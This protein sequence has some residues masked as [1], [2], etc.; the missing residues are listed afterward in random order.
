MKKLLRGCVSTSQRGFN[1]L[2]IQTAGAAFRYSESQLGLRQYSTSHELGR[3]VNEVETFD[4]TC[5]S[6][7]SITVDLYNKSL[8]TQPTH[9]LFL[10]LPSTG[11]HLRSNHPPIPSFLASDTT[12]LACI[13]YRWNRISV[14]SQCVSTDLSSASYPSPPP[15]P[16]LLSS[17]PSFANHAFPTPLHDT[18]HA[19]NYLT[20]SLLPS[21]CPLEAPPKS[22]TKSPFSPRSRYYNPPTPAPSLIQRPLIIYG[23]YLGA[24]LATSLALTES[25]LSKH[26]PYYIAGLIAADGIYDWTHISAS[27]PPPPLD[28]PSNIP[29]P[30]NTLWDISQLYNIRTHLFTS[31]ASTFDAFASPILFFRTAGLHVPPTWPTTTKDVEKVQEAGEVLFGDEEG[32]IG[33]N[34]DGPLQPEIIPGKTITTMDLAP[35]RK[36]HLKF[37]SKDSGI[38]IP[39]SLFLISPSLSSQSTTQSTTPKKKARGKKSQDLRLEDVINPAGQ[40]NELAEAMRRSVALHELKDRKTWDYDLDPYAEADKRVEV[41]ENGSVNGGNERERIQEWIEE[42]LEA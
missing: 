34:L 1:C 20:K 33:S 31:P 6:A 37:Q 13:N 12:A 32:L 18:L 2:S 11:T 22:P 41:L 10:Y 8:L 38:K 25:L 3:D 17:H 26:L 19:F 35:P 16:A 30:T 14:S 21:L 5:G 39:K 28:T 7:G 27:P 9:P 15:S 42:S 29:Q 36:S 24:T 4:V 23:S 40:A